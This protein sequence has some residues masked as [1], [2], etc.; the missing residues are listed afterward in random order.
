MR[1]S[2]A[3]PRPPLGAPD[4]GMTER[5]RPHSY[6]ARR[7]PSEPDML[8]NYGDTTAS[9]PFSHKGAVPDG[10]RSDRFH[11]GVKVESDIRA[12]G[13]EEGELRGRLCGQAAGSGVLEGYAVGAGYGDADGEFVRGGPSGETGLWGYGQDGR[14]K[15]RREA[16]REPTCVGLAGQGGQTGG[17]SASGQMGVQDMFGA[18]VF[19]ADGEV[20]EVGTMARGELYSAGGGGNAGGHASHGGGGGVLNGGGH[21]GGGGLVGMASRAPTSYNRYG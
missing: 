17:G 14:A 16:G 10:R 6:T 19:A 1:N 21:S 8:F 4:V 7:A 9:G 13:A 2:V 15:R 11:Q 3:I 5:P 12:S 20:A 18:G